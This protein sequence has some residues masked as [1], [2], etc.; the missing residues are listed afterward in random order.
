MIVARHFSGGTEMHH[1]SSP[2]GTTEL[3]HTAPDTDSQAQ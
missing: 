1:D 3:T 2:V